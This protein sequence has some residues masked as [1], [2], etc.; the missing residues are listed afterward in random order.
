MTEEVRRKASY[1]D[2]L[3]APPH[4]VAEVLAGEFYTQPRPSPIL[5]QA[6][7][8]LAEAL[9]PPF[10]RG[11]GGPGG[12]IIL[13]EPELHLGPGPDIIVPDLA[14]WRRETLPEI[15]EAAF[16]SVVPDWVCE[17][18]SP[19]TRARDRVLKMRIYARERVPYVWLVDPEACTL[20]V[21]RLDGDH[22]S[23]SESYVDGVEVRAEPFEAVPIDLSV[24]WMR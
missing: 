8:S 13:F 10:K 14:G 2:V 9:G 7:S 11:K 22:Y 4:L 15:P 12:W 6:T 17:T 24:L 20:E 5:A 18:L 3:N 21:F 23:L 16:V 19:S 1:R